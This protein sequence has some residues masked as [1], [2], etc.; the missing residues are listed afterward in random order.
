MTE[1][2]LSKCTFCNQKIVSTT[3][4]KVRNARLKHEEKCKKNP[5]SK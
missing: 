5:K 2:A 3:I 1:K 4:P